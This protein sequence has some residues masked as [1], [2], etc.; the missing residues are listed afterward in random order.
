MLVFVEVVQTTSV[1]AGRTTDD[2]MDLVALGE[3]KLS[4]ADSVSAPPSGSTF[5]TRFS[6]IRS[7]L[8][9]DTWSFR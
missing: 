5:W 1:E 4:T 3:Q 8:S 6:Q 2:A 7:I 9:G